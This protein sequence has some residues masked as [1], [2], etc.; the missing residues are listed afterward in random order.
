MANI[1]GQQVVEKA[2]RAG[3][4]RVRTTAFLSIL[5]ECWSQHQTEIAGRMM[6]ATN[7]VR[8]LL[9]TLTSRT[10][11]Y[12]GFLHEPGNGFCPT[13]DLKLVKDI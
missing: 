13:L 6:A 7:V 12:L 2:R 10:T 9:E 3:V 1:C 11:G 4:G 8:S 5:K